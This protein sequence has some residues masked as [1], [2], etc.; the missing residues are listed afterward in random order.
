MRTARL[1]GV[2]AV[3]LILLGLAAPATAAGSS[4]LGLSWDG[5]NWSTELVGTLFNRPGSIVRWVPGDS[6]TE[7]F[8]VRNQGGDAARVA[9]DYQLPPNSLVNDTDFA[10]TASVDGG[11][12]VALTP[13]SGWL[14]LGGT[15]LADGRAA[16]VAVTATF[17][18][19]ST[20][21]SQSEEFPLDFRVTL[22]EIAGPQGDINKHGHS[23][24]QGNGNGNLN[25]QGNGQANPSNGESGH[26]A[27]LLPD[28]GAPEVRWALGAG[29][30]CLGGG[31]ALVALSRRRER[32]AEAS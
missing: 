3:L 21:P 17:R 19:T 10:L 28:T 12:P 27:G 31:I 24:G 9:I 4:Q 29:L 1:A 32:D 7:H 20:N 8:F 13:G 14:A 5:T 6:D 30:L 23:T 11:P 26:G 22:T 15:T 16:E 2:V 25:G 18:A